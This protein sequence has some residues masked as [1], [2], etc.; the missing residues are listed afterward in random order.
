M[1][2]LRYMAVLHSIESSLPIPGV[3]SLGKCEALQ[4]KLLPAGNAMRR[5]S[6]GTPDEVWTIGLK[7]LLTEETVDEEAGGVF[8]DGAGAGEAEPAAEITDGVVA[9]EPGAT[10]GS[11]E[12]LLEEVAL[13]VGDRGGE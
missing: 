9:V 4:I 2:D 10:D 5:R 13:V 3:A 7:A 12:L 6:W 11:E 1:R 8:D